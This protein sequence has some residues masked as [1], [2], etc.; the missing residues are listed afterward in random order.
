MVPAADLGKLAGVP[1]PVMDAVVFL[2]GE[3]TGVD[4]LSSGQNL[5]SMGLTGKTTAEIK[6]FVNG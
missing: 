4:F 5:D 3:A 1:T 2:L 6:Q